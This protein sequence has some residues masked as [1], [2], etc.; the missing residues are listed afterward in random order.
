[1]EIPIHLSKKIKLFELAKKYICYGEC[2]GVKNSQHELIALIVGYNNNSNDRKAYI[3][4]L[5]VL[6]E[7]Q[8]CGI[9]SRLISKFEEDCRKKGMMEIEVFTHKTNSTAIRLY[10]HNGF[11]IDMS[12][13][14]RPQDFK[15]LKEL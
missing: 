1:M 9:A 11:M 13:E 5:V 15:Y 12:D 4:L 7:Y 8:G 10:E 3:S 6:P 14:S 2:I